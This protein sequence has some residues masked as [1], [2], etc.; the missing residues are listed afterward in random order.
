M[1]GTVP[2]VGRFAAR[3]I[4][5]LGA[6]AMPSL[7]GLSTDAVNAFI[8]PSGADARVG[9]EEGDRKGTVWVVN[10]DAGTLAVFDAVSGDYLLKTLPLFVGNGAHDIC[11]SEQTGKAYITAETDNAVTVVDMQTLEMESIPVGPMPHHIEPSNDGHTI[12]VGLASHAAAV[13]PAQYAVIDTTDH[14]VRY[15]TSTNPTDFARAHGITPTLGGDRVYIAHDSG[16]MVTGLDTDSGEV[17]LTVKQIP[18]AEEVVPSRFGDLLWVSA[19]GDNTVKRIDL[20]SGT[21]TASVPVDV[22]GKGIQPESIMLTPNELALVVSLRGRPAS[23]AFID[24]LALKALPLVRIGPED[25]SAGDL[26][27]MTQN[28]HFVYATYDNDVAGTGG[29]AVVDV[30]TR[31]LVARWPYPTTGRPHGIWYSK[32]QP[33]F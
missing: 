8:R 4:I 19:R 3:L 33:R 24:T 7:S 16:N 6:L 25:N 2:S 32:K 5:V 27:V 15:M 10:R 23:L 17:G 31:E 30:R 20:A 11:I 28:G 18:R 13:A 12:Y 26:A 9:G 22:E 1:P 29:V 21:V 14:S